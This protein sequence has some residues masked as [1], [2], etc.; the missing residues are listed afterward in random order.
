MP[1]PFHLF[2]NQTNFNS[3]NLAS[4]SVKGLVKANFT[5]SKIL[6]AVED[7]QKNIQILLGAPLAESVLHFKSSINM[8][9]AGKFKKANESLRLVR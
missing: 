2:T 4:I 9:K 3:K 6:N 7:I 5:L 8:I 1:F